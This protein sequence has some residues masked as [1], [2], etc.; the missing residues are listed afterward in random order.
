[1]DRFRLPILLLLNS[2]FLKICLN[3]PQQSVFIA[4]VPA[5]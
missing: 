4:A 1:V 2:E 3:A 5:N